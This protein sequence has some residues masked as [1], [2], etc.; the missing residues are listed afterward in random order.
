M[1]TERPQC[2]VVLQCT[3]T[4]CAGQTIAD[5]YLGPV[6]CLGGIT[7]KVHPPAYMAPVALVTTP[8][9]TTADTITDRG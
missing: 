1:S 6:R 7:Q 4:G 3:A 5:A 8:R 2:R 9:V